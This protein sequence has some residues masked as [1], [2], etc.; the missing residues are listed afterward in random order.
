V[1][2]RSRN[3][4]TQGLLAILKIRAP[5]LPTPH[6]GHAEAPCLAMGLPERRKICTRNGLFL[7]RIASD[8]TRLGV[9]RS[10]SRPVQEHGHTRALGRCSMRSR[11]AVAAHDMAPRRSRPLRAGGTSRSPVRAFNA[12]EESRP[13][14]SDHAPPTLRSHPLDRR[15]D[16]VVSSTSAAMRRCP[17]VR[18]I[19]STRFCSK[20][21]GAARA[22]RYGTVRVPWRVKKGPTCPRC[23]RS[24]P[25]R[26]RGVDEH[27][28]RPW[29]RCHR[30]LGASLLCRHAHLGRTRGLSPRRPGAARPRRPVRRV[31]R[32]VRAIA[33]DLTGRSAVR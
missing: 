33:A 5:R 17:A 1:S 31:G 15:H 7:T 23:R 26:C 13:P 18:G 24:V 16:V 11:T 22:R 3:S 28:E 27:R 6:R 30:M 2:P 10:R 29:P 14:R 12:A 8:S 4:V 32:L 25:A 9:V 19:W 21:G 20:C